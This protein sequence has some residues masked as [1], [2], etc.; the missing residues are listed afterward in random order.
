MGKKIKIRTFSFG[1]VWRISG[2]GFGLVTGMEN[3]RI[4]DPDPYNNSHGSAS[5]KKK[6]NKFKGIVKTCNFVKIR[7]TNSIKN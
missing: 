5:L 1:Y 6:L 4:Q 3:F 7:I 2:Y